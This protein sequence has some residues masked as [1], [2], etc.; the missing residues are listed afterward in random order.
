MSLES[1]MANLSLRGTE[2]SGL[3]SGLSS[4]ATRVGDS[5]G[6]SRDGGARGGG[7]K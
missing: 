5:V 4:Q 3:E 1:Y 6:V 2:S 7:K